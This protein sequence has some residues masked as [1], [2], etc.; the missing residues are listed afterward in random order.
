MKKIVISVISLL[1]FTS[2]VS[3]KEIQENYLD[4]YLRKIQNQISQVKSDKSIN[5]KILLANLYKDKG[6]DLNAEQITL[7]ILKNTPGN[8]QALFLLGELNKRSYKLL[9]A[10]EIFSKIT[11][12]NPEYK[13]TLF[14]LLEINIAL[15]DEND[16]EKIISILNKQNDLSLMNTG[17]GIY[18]SSSFKLDPVKA[19]E[20]F[21]KAISLNHN[22]LEAKYYLATILL[23]K[24]NRKDARKLFNEVISADFSF[25]AA[26]S[27][28]G[29]MEFIDGNPE[30][31]VKEIKTGLRV[32]PMDLRARTS[33]GNGMTTLTYKELEAGK[34]YLVQTD[35]FINTG[36]QAVDLINQGK[37]RDARTLTDNLIKK[38][39]EN[40]HSYI[41]AG[42]L[43]VTIGEYEEAIAFFNKALSISQDY[44]LANNGLSIAIRGFIKNQEKNSAKL[45]LDIFDYSQLNMESLKKV[46]INYGDLPEKYQKIVKYSIFPLKNYLPVL[47]ASGST[48]YIIPLYERSTDYKFGV[49]YKNQR[50]FDYRLWDDI[51][52]RGG[53]NSATGIEDLQGSYNLDFNTLTHEFTHQVHGFAMTQLQ[54]EKIKVLFSLAKRDKRFLDYYA[55]SNEYEY[56][57]QGVEAY[58]STQGKQTLKAT[59]KNTRAL[60]YKTDKPLYDFIVEATEINDLKENFAASYT[61]KGDNFYYYGDFVEAENAYKAALNEVPDY[62]TAL[63]SLGNLYRYHKSPVD[64]KTLH[65]RA[66]NKYPDKA[67]AYLNLGD[68]EYY[69]SGNY[70][71]S[72]ENFQKAHEVEPK[73][74]ETIFRLANAYLQVGNIKESVSYYKRA[75]QNDANSAS[76]NLGLAYNYIIAGKYIKAEE[77][78]KKALTIDPDS[79]S[80][81]AELARL[82][83]EDNLPEKTEEELKKA[84]NIDKENPYVYSVKGLYELQK[85]NFEQGLINLQEAVKLDPGNLLF[86]IRLAYAYI[87]KRDFAMADSMLNRI[88][89]EFE[90]N[91]LP[92]T[93]FDKEKNKYYSYNIK[94]IPD[95][96]EYYYI[97]GLK[98]ELAGNRDEAI[99]AYE[100]S[101]VI[102]P[103]FAKPYKKLAD[104]SF[105][106]KEVQSKM[107]ELSQSLYEKLKEIE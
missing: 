44:G 27:M 47:A 59:S 83:L 29:F 92:V 107:K 73:N 80:T 26:H 16:S 106:N 19:A 93:T 33:S 5:G 70:I 57:A 95:K 3:A 85:H 74:Q 62:Y 82:Y 45:N 48:H 102:L 67:D 53:F 77:Y 14:K 66:I 60:L 64:A 42:S 69:L 18:F 20:Y 32:N 39:P 24:N 15:K 63:N 84:A 30:K 36:K 79:P 6:E 90:N 89:Q 97:L 78:L 56:F 11:G 51:R 9:K 58:N 12:A 68:D 8:S 101:I 1:V 100:K 13:K 105:T 37:I 4:E 72:F 98:A 87:L 22:N 99:S 86:K 54:Q 31:A 21:Q 50:S 49:E 43:A 96:A 7:E 2:Y 34:P 35:E 10:K 65:Q 81:L 28:L 104:I 103:Y 52:G 46:F 38:Y 76:A 71:K 40:I 88:G 41:Q 55:G 25:S 75:R 23:D 61:Q 94:T 91:K 17:M